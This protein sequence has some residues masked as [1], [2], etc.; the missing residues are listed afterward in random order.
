MV[1]PQAQAQVDFWRKAHIQAMEL[2]KDWMLS[3]GNISKKER[4]G[5]WDI[6]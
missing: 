5:Q 2:Y 4:D 3:M 6:R 1:Q